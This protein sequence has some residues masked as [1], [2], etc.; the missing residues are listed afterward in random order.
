MGVYVNDNGTLRT[1]TRA[2]VNDNGTLRELDEFA[3]RDNATLRHVYMIQVQ[4]PASILA[5]RAASSPAGMQ[6]KNDGTMQEGSSTPSAELPLTWLVSGAVADY[7]YNMSAPGGDGFSTGATDTWI[8]GGTSTTWTRNAGLGQT[9]TATG[10]LKIRRASDHVELD[11]CA[12]TLE[13]DNS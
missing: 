12:V 4:L 6:F 1:I 13:C 3:V 7:E 2:F 10:T 8:S 9:R 5:Q 11:S